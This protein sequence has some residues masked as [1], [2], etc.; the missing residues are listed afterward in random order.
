MTT[1]RAWIGLLGVLLAASP[2]T[3]GAAASDVRVARLRCEYLTNPIG[4]DA[5]EPRLSWTIEAARRGVRQ[6]AYQILAATSPAKLAPGA[7]DLWDSGRVASDRSIQIHYAGKRLESRQRCYWKLKIWDER[8]QPSAWSE[9]GQWTMGLLDP[10]DWKAEWIGLGAPAAL[11]VERPF[12][13]DGAQWIWPEPT[14]LEANPVG[15]RRYFRRTFTLDEEPLFRADVVLLTDT[16]SYLYVNGIKVAPFITYTSARSVHIGEYLRPGKNVLAVVAERTE[17]YNLP[18][19]LVTG[20]DIEYRSGRQVR[21]QSDESWVATDKVSD[22]WEK[23]DADET[24]WHPTQKLGV[25]GDEPWGRRAAPRVS[26]PV[27]LLRK[28][29]ALRPG[30][31]RALIHATA[32]GI[33]ELYLNGRRVGDDFFAPGWTAYEKRLFYRSYDVTQLVQ[34][35]RANAIGAQ[36]ADGWYTLRHKGQGNERLLAQL[37]VEY[38]DGTRQVVGT[39][40]SWLAS[41][42]GPILMADLFNGE[43]Y[44]ARRE[45]RGWAEVGYS[46]EGWQPVAVSPKTKTPL[47]AHPGVPVRKLM[48]LHPR[49]AKE[50]RPGTH[51]LDLGQNFAGWCRLKVRGAAGTRVQLRFAEMLNRDGTLFTENLRTAQVT[52][53]YV[54]KGAGEEVWEPRFTFHGFQYV[55]VS[56]Y[57][58][59][60]PPD[61][62]TGV[63]LHSD[64]P[65]VGDFETSNPMLNRLFQNVAWSTRA[66]YFEIPT[67]CPQRD[68]RM[69]WTG[70]AQVFIRSGTYFMDAASFFTAWLATL[71]DDVDS[72]GAYPNYSPM[73]SAPFGFDPSPGWGDAG[74]ICPYALFQVYDDRT[75][76]ERHYSKMAGWIDFMAGERQYLAPDAEYLKEW[77]QRDSRRYGFGDW[78]NLDEVPTPK[79]LIGA[80]YHAHTIKLMSK[81]AEALGRQADAQRYA[82]RFEETRAVFVRA[83]VTPEGRVLGDTQTGYLL[84]LAFDLLPAELR[85]RAAERLVEKIAANDWRLSTGFLGVNLLLPTL[86]EIGRTDV[87]YRLLTNTVY[88]SWGYSVNNGATTIW[89]RWN[90]W[91]REGGINR[92]SMNS[93]NHYA[94]GSCLEWMF[95]TMAGIDTDGPGFKRL[96]IRPRPGGG[97]TH[98]RAAYDSIHG[99]IKSEWR[100]DGLR[101]A[102]DVTIPANVTARVYIPA[103]GADAVTEGGHSVA[104]SA[105][106]KVVGMEGGSLVLEAGSG[107]Y[108]FASETAL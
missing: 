107:S 60:L 41:S 29:F 82:Q 87:A 3:A 38:E 31:K 50:I 9:A 78:L 96:R 40:G 19:A 37:E 57:P 15:T 13:I 85:P 1:S 36:L 34:A 47:E 28:E 7:A 84:A 74:V 8:G 10:A 93:F 17:R 58:G 61:A 81:V 43:V 46:T 108:S 44:D 4:V 103:R 101:F 80:A 69:G 54:L 89:E 24:G 65:I 52:D 51:I 70:D 92:E 90:A 91:T 63:V 21:I 76:L 20:L 33:Y 64:A 22:G 106:L 18:P 95:T 62:I 2:M 66:N 71:N 83:Y 48:E 94:Y 59:P 53:V 55:E 49:S 14:T 86:T 35:G 45:R 68:E 32:L 12:A 99:P 97:I 102:L 42:D 25:Y 27:R 72:R 16:D 26:Y 104:S 5:R 79:F 105:G 73:A 6:Q 75:V 100:L 39:D 56:G 30:I 23:L 77:T 88:P 67:D 98:V 11:A